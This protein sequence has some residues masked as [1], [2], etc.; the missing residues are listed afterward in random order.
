MLVSL[1]AFY[2]AVIVMLFAGCTTA[3]A[4][5]SAQLALTATVQGD[6][7]RVVATWRPSCDRRGCAETYRVDVTRGDLPRPTKTTAGL[8][9]TTWLAAPAWGDSVRV[10]VAVIPVRRGITGQA[11]T[12]S[13]WLK[14]PDAPPA[15]VDSLSID[16]IPLTPQQARAVRD[17]AVA[18]SYPVWEL[19]DTTGAPNPIVAPGAQLQW[20]IAARN[21]YD[22]SVH[23]ITPDTLSFSEYTQHVQSCERARA[24]Y[25]ARRSG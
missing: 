2:A 1:L 23:L 25:A 19:M 16:T 21:R 7:A 5:E 9:D 6:S 24:A 18:D 15:P 12:A 11:R 22:G 14:R 4:S 17:A 8:T 10:T 20:C 13:L 3:G